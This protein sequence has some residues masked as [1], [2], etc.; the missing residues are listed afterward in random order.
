MNKAVNEAVNKNKAVMVIDVQE[1]FFKFP[2]IELYQ[3]EELVADIN[4]LI[5]K[6]RAGG[7]PVIFI[8]H[9]EYDY[10]AD[11][12]Y[13]ESPGWPIHHGLDRKDSDPVIRKSV[14]SAFHETELA[15]VL[16]ER[17]IEQ[18][19]FAG[20]QTDFC[21]NATIRAAHDLGFKDNILL[22]N[23]HS[24]VDSPEQTAQEII[25]RHEQDWQEGRFVTILDL[26]Q[27]EL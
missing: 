18:L 25:S 5:G 17:S 27:I 19:V 21:I 20:A 1:A 26:D 23:G 11:E 15:S 2:E 3:K 4:R 9:T 22:K 24:T 6:A 7:V 10:P 16:K 12:F 8:Q 14:P 13:L